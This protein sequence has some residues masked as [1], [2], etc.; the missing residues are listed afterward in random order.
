[1]TAHHLRLVGGGPGATLAL[2][3]H[4]KAALAAVG[5]PK[6]V[7]AYVGAASDDNGGF[8][9]MIRGAL[10]LGSGARMEL[11]RVASPRAKASDARAL[12]EACDLVFVSGGDVEHGMKVL[13][14]RDVA[15]T[16][17]ALGRAGK[18]FFG[19]SAGAL[20]LA[21]EWVRFPDE[22][23]DASAELF[24]CLGLAPIHVD[25]HSEEDDWSEL[26]VLVRLLH[27]R[28]DADPVGYGLTAKGG[29]AVS[30][31][32]HGKARLRALGTP[33]PRLV[34]R[35]GKVTHGAPLAPEGDGS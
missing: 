13:R 28:G 6:P 35:S 23:H 34:V 5:K 3:R 33:I 24:P 1:M 20:M 26:R 9:T 21:R 17:V 8:F 2:R 25:A 10:A 12:L 29:L 31:G 32:E 19:I 7:V 30:V 22:E 11:A 14:E 4:F 18:P 16:L 27:E 15:P